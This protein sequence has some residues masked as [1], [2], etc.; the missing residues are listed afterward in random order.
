MSK[1][2][3]HLVGWITL[4][5]FPIPAF[6][7]LYY[8]EGWS[9][10]DF[11]AFDDLNS[12]ALGYGIELGIIYA[13]LATLILA[14]PIFKQVPLKMDELIR[15]M[16]LN[17]L[18]ALFLSVCAGVGEELLFRVGVQYYLGPFFTSI[19]FV[20]V[21]GYLNPFNWRMSLYG[22]VVLPLSFVLGYGYE[23]FGLWFSIAV[24]F[25]YD[26]TLFILFIWV[27]KSQLNDA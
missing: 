2:K 15:S 10:S 23:S 25:A 18:D 16:N 19:L 12:I 8:L 1:T 4:I 24:H 11:L 6:L 21:H 26:A 17:Y 7:V 14:A 20:A 5:G 9:L 27:D 13:F 22:L 3:L